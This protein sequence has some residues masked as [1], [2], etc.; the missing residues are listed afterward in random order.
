[1]KVF[2]GNTKPTNY[3]VGDMWVNATLEGKFNNDIAR[4]VATSE[5]FNADDWVLASRYSEAIAT[6]QKW[7]N[8]YETK[9][10]NL[11]DEVKK[12]KDQ[13]II[14]WYLEYEPTLKN[15]P[16][17]GWNENDKSEHIGDIVYD[18]ENNHSYR[19]TGTA[20]VQIKDAD[21]DKAMKAAKDADDKANSKRRIF[22]SA[23]TP[24]KPFDKGDLWI[25][26]VGDKTETWVY[27]GTNWV[28]SDDKTL[29]DFKNAINEELTGIKGQLDGKAETWYQNTNP[30]NEKTGVWESG[31]TDKSH[32]GDIW[33]N[34]KDGITNYWNGSAWEQMD[35]PKDVFNTIDG[36]SSIFVDSYADAKAGLGVI[37][38]GYKERDL[39][40]LPEDATVNGV[41]CY[42]GD[43]LTAVSNNK[44]FDETNWKKKVRYIGPT[45][46]TSVSKSSFLRR[47]KYSI[48]DK[49]IKV[50]INTR[51]CYIINSINLFIYYI[52]ST[53]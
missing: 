41:E 5:V 6:I 45:E 25:K 50:F 11:A 24:T 9:F 38:N 7:T 16:A 26:Q 23:T 10:G 1:M 43:I 35:I 20:W 17:F 8:E 18:I 42:K 39:W 13:S 33:Y 31:G 30:R 53:S 19:W 22:Y 37:C 21:F 34:T 40:I 48:F 52:N 51:N 47:I 32:K 36:K 14:V 46:L 2:Y 29:A 28:K 3:Q 12:Q 15:L 4:A 49:V 44:N 27:N